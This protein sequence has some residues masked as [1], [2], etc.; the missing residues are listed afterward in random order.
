MGHHLGF[1]LLL[2]VPHILGGLVRPDPAVQVQENFDLD[3]F[4][5]RWYSIAIASTF[6]WRSS[7]TRELLMD[8][9]RLSRAAAEDGVTM[10]WTTQRSGQCIQTTSDLGQRERPGHWIYRCQRSHGSETDA[11]V[12][13]TNYVEY[14]VILLLKEHKGA[15]TRTAILYGREQ[16]LRPSLMSDFKQFAKEQGVAEESIILLPKSDECV[17]GETRPMRRQVRRRRNTEPAEEPQGS[18]DTMEFFQNEDSCKLPQDHGPCYGNEIRYFYNSSLML[19]QRFTYG[20]CLGNSNRFLS[21]KN[22]LQRCRTEAACRLP[23]ETGT[24]NSP[25]NLWAF[26][27]Q[28]GKCI[29]FKYSGCKGNGNKFYSQKECEEFCGI[30]KEGEEGLLN[31]SS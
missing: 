7:Q 21:E 6:S 8:T 25:T 24:C 14:A 5:G 27:S 30:Q 1:I 22:C 19:C 13:H 18:G 10:T 9:I 3:K 28:K 2:F 15:M 4:L 23:I 11:Y 31:F 26:D 12:V 17:P 16:E 29:S 20:G